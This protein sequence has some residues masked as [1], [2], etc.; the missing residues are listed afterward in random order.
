MNYLNDE[1]KFFKILKQNVDNFIETH[2]EYKKI[3]IANMLDTNIA[4]LNAIQNMTR[5]TSFWTCIKIYFKL[6]KIIAFSEC[7]DFY[8]Y[9]NDIYRYYQNMLSILRIK[10][11]KEMNNKNLD[12]KAMADKLN[13]QPTVLK[14]FKD[15]EYHTNPRTTTL[16]KIL[17][18]FDLELFI[19]DC[20]D[21]IEILKYLS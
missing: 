17:N 20:S 9:N 12:I 15:E 3:E 10:I 11:D 6:K 8:L 19:S 14:Y 13:I 5:Q 4:T 21:E 18:Y 1:T 7:G 2:K 16:L